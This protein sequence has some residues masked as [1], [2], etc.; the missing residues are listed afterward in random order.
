MRKESTTYEIQKNLGEQWESI[1]CNLHSIYQARS[2]CKAFQN[3]APDIELR[4][5][6]REIIESLAK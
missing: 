3:D 5:I 6:K 4:I 2:A 1:T